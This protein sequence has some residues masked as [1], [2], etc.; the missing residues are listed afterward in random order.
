MRRT[1]SGLGG[2]GG[3]RHYT[4]AADLS[5]KEQQGPDG[6]PAADDL[7]EGHEQTEETHRAA[8]RPTE[9][10]RAADARLRLRF[11]KRPLG[12]G[13]NRPSSV[14]PDRLISSKISY[15]VIQFLLEAFDYYK[16][17]IYIKI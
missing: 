14:A 1:F 5:R 8:V 15:I 13:A 6:E 12:G 16:K 4:F 11:V 17:K 7:A 9:Q 3:R 2:G 10:G